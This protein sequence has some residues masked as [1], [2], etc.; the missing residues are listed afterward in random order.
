MKRVLFAIASLAVVSASQATVL[1]FE[2]SGGTVL[3][4]LTINPGNG[5]GDRVATVNQGGFSYGAAGG[6]TP[7]VVVDYSAASAI[8]QGWATG[9]GDLVNVIWGNGP[10]SGTNT[11]FVTLT[12]DP[13]WLVSLDRFDAAAWAGTQPDAVIR[14]LRPSSA[15]LTVWNGA[16]PQGSQGHLT[17]DFALAPIVDSS[18]T[19]EVTQGWWHALDN[20]EFSQQPVPE[21]ATMA[22]LGLAAA[23]F[24]ARRR[25]S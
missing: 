16:L 1:I 2:T 5:Y 9:Y 15:P 21:P 13:G 20:I 8:P 24:A 22:I 6:F 7:N 3:G 25:K 10:S 17:V 18:I 14:I 4:D 19:I 23:G 11:Y 12:A